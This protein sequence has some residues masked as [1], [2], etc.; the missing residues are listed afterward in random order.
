MCITGDC[1]QIRRQEPSA[2]LQHATSSIR[3]PRIID[4]NARDDR[5]AGAAINPVGSTFT[6]SK[7]FAFDRR[8]AASL[9][10]VELQQRRP[11]VRTSERLL[12]SH[13]HGQRSP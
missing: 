11:A 3:L 13:Q 10:L 8:H 2:H 9:L 1:R 5:T 4:S 7:A 6:E 12:P